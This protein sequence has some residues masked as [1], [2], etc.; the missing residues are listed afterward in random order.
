MVGD[1]KLARN[2]RLKLKIQDR[3]PR[4]EKEEMVPDAFTDQTISTC[5]SSFLYPIL[6]SFINKSLYHT[7]P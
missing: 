4:P 5:T 2:V 3:V 7:S 6:Q 1:V